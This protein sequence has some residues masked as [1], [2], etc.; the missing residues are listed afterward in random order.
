[1]KGR[2][3]MKEPFFYDTTLRDG[4][5]ALKKTWN[6]DEK[7]IIFNE[8]IELG[9]QGIEV[10]FPIASEMDFNAC[11]L[12]AKKTPG[13]VVASV[14]ARA[15]KKDIEAAAEAVKYAKKPRIHTF[16]TM[17]PLGLK[18][19]L[20]KDLPTV[21]QMAI[22]S[23]KYAKKLLPKGEVEF[24]VEHFGDCRENLPQVIEAL[25]KIVKAGADVINLPNTVERF[26]P[27]EFTSMVEQVYSALR[28]KAVLSIH[29][30]NDLGMAT[31]TTVEGFFSGAAQLET[32]LNGIGE[33][34]GNTNMYEVAVALYN[35][36]VKVPLKMNRF[37]NS[38]K[39]V[40]NMSKIPVWEK[41][42]IIGSDVL[43][44]RSG[45]HQDGANKTKGLS[46]GQYIAFDPRLIG[47][48][49]GEQ[50]S[51]TSQSGKSALYTIYQERGYQITH[52]EIEYLMP[53]AKT[54]AEKHGELSFKH[55]D[56]LYRHHLCTVKGN[57]KFSSFNQIS[58]DK[59]AVS[60]S[61]KDQQIDTI[62]KGKGPVESC[63]NAL[64]SLGV[65]ISVMKYEQHM[66]NEKEKEAA[67]AMTVMILAKGD[68][69]IV[70]RAI[71]RSTNQSNIKAIFNGLNRLENGC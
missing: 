36:G 57:Y 6:T 44:H 21:T 34:A 56:N 40:S 58:N 46:K 8:L 64:L 3:L 48:E 11:K 54:M 66:M 42:P 60:F 16:I 70:A 29:C 27:R 35:T 67:E 52:E 69:K 53:F 4:N 1:M 49:D 51:F 68:K 2:K 33:R 47:R 45:I 5:Q 31:A 71:D 32:T 18:Y 59:Y 65:A 55:L 15:N 10:G 20:K 62:G 39:L 19:V 25:E 14:L 13:T 22:D 43:A 26:R 24:S 7:Q 30:H 9:V 50:L 41:A 63:I 61:Y 37:Y 38:S 28:E 23:V 12:L 17:N